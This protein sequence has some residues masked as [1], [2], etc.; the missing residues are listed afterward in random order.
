[1]NLSNYAFIMIDGSFEQ[2]QTAELKSPKMS[3]NFFCVKD[4]DQAITIV[5]QLKEKQVDLIELCGGF[6]PEMVESIKLAT[7]NEIAIGKVEYGQDQMSKLMA[8]MG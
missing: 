1:M 3:A 8:L 6:Q 4:I 7:N 2:T 5:K